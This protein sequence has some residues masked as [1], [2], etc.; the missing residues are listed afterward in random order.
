MQSREFADH[1]ANARLHNALLLSAAI[2][3]V[4]SGIA[5]R[6]RLTWLLEVWPVAVAGVILTLTYRRFRFS[7]LA[8]CLMWVHALVL[9]LG[10]HWTYAE[11]PLFNWLRDAFD[12]QRNYYDR[13]GHLAQGFIPAILARELL[14][15]TSPLRPG[16]WLFTLALACTLAVSA[17]YELLEWAAATTLGQDADEFLATQGDVWDTQWDM[18]LALLGGTA[19]LVLLRRVHDRSI[20][21]AG[22]APPAGA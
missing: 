4:W 13:L 19:A 7:T 6:D 12:L 8:Y 14:L 15:R 9:M 3:L 20:Q 21:R 11:M 1:P 16:K 10:G 5:P 22:L 18:F 2:I 17:L